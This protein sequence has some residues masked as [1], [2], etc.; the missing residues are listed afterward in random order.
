MKLPSLRALTST[1][2]ILVVLLLCWWT[3]RAIPLQAIWQTLR[4]LTPTTIAWLVLANLVVLITLAGRWWLFLY[5]QGYPISFVR[6]L[7]YRIAAFAVSYFTPGPHVGGEPLQVYLV[8]KYHGV[9]TAVSIA[10]VTL[11]KLLDLVI[12][13]AVLMAGVGLILQQQV[14]TDA[15]SQ[16]TLYV[17]LG[18]LC[19]PLLLLGALG[20]GRYPLSGL[21]T[22]LSRLCAARVQRASTRLAGW[23]QTIRQS[24]EQ[25]I[26]LWRATPAIFLGACAISLLSWGALVGEFWY[27]TY[28]LGLAVSFPQAITLLL[29]MRIAILLPMPA[30]LGVLEASLAMATAA[31]GLSPAAGV[32]MGL[33]IRLRDV[34]VG[35]VGLWVGGSLFWPNCVTIRARIVYKHCLA[36]LSRIKSKWQPTKD[37]RRWLRL[38]SGR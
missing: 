22:K 21:L 33:L 13:L 11:D 5:G 16:R 24:E 26:A 34:M 35:I 23:A 14:L 20:R 30:G 1:I 28:A 19:L 38:G 10:A 25:A 17:T 27:M 15:L 9:P 6:L 18:M 32:S 8:S 37:G 36:T 3:L 7:G 31:L 29:A 2:L 4:H 12:N